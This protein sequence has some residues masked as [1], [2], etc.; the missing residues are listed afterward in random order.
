[1][2]TRGGGFEQVPRRPWPSRRAETVGLLALEPN[3]FTDRFGVQ[4]VDDYDNLDFYKEAMIRLPSGRLVS[5]VRYL[6]SPSPGTEIKASADDDA[7]A[8][9]AELLDALRLRPDV[10]TWTLQMPSDRRT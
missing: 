2:S 5:L 4:F 7:A 6:R 9:R 8:A 1:M 3:D 10:L